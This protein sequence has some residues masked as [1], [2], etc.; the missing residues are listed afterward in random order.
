MSAQGVEGSYDVV[1]VGG[2]PGGLA[3]ATVLA[4]AGFKVLV[5]ER[6]REPGAKSLFGGKVYAQPLRDV[7]PDLDRKAPIHRWV[8]VERF[9]LTK[10]DRVATVEYRLGRPVAF[11][12][13]LPEL[14]KWMAAK[15]EE[16]GA[17]VVDE[18]VVDEILVKD[19]SVAGV[20]SGGD[21]VK[22]RVVV[23]AEGVNR[24]L[25]ERLGLVDPPDPSRLALGVKEVIRLKPDEIEARF[26]LDR[27]EGLAWLIAGDITNWLPG[28]GFVYTMNDSVSVGIV[29][30]V[31]SAVEAA[32]RGLIREHVSRMVERLRLH[33]YF[34]RFWA[35]GD[36]AEYGGR[37]AIEGGLG[38]MPRKLAISGLVVVGDAAGLLLNTGYTIRGVDFAAYSGK[39]AA[40]T[41][42]HALSKGDTSEETLRVYEEKLKSSFVYKELVRHR[43]IERVMSDP[44]FFKALPEISVGV[45]ARL[46]EA[47][48]EEPTIAEALLEAAREA[49]T[50]LPVAL[51]RLLS[52]A[53]E[54]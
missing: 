10:G 46:F 6:G 33:P 45:L 24:M 31:A 4:R 5:L 9:S 40:E 13:Y 1:V 19:G 21:E 16:A 28:G 15:A 39:L 14:V 34:K 51:A 25:L 7:W 54:L 18:V 52:V 22:A 12:T 48:Y 47:D 53:G 43:G 32:E 27:K 38:Y 26:G 41:I 42:I 44:W 30:R 20:R 36:I 37:L 17:L 50:P 49:G 3:A 23:D 2:G 29:L 8:R 35:G 11:T